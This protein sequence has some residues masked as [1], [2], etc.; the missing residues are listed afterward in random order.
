MVVVAHAL[1]LAF[2][3]ALIQAEGVPRAA[4]TLGESHEKSRMSSGIMTTLTII[5]NESIVKVQDQPLT[6]TIQS[7]WLGAA[8]GR[9]GSS[10]LSGICVLSRAR[11]EKCLQKDCTCSFLI[12][13]MEVMLRWLSHLIWRCRRVFRA[14]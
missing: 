6:P 13:R 8:D 10:R 14:R 5:T 4:T 1:A 11:L 3:I 12:R 7:Q 2:N 9:R